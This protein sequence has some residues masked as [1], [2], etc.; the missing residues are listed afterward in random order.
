MIILNAGVPRSGTVLVNAIVR[1]LLIRN[2]ISARQFDPHEQE[3]SMLLSQL[4]ERRRYQWQVFLIHTHSWGER[5]KRLLEGMERFLVGFATYRDPRDVCVSLM[6]LHEHTF[7][8]ALKLTGGYYKYF[9]AT[10]RDVSLMQIPYELLVAEKHAHIFQIARHLGFQLRLDALAA[11]DEATS[12]DRHRTVMEEVK[13]GKREGVISRPNPTRTILEDRE[14]LIN[15]RHIQSGVV[16]RWRTELTAE[17][18]ARVNEVFR[19]ILDTY[20]YPVDDG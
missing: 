19:P 15:D 17:Q 8:R 3:L 4:R 1:E 20:G 13:S 10:C 14:T 18:Q 9:E 12:V 7:E 11:I 2:G 5:S 6:R 16:G